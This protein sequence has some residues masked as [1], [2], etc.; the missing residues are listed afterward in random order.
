MNAEIHY[1]DMGSRSIVHLPDT[2]PVMCGSKSEAFA[3]LTARGDVKHDKTIKRGGIMVERYIITV[4]P[5]KVATKATVD[6]D[7]WVTVTVPPRFFWDHVDRDLVVH[8]GKAEFDPET[9]T[10]S[11]PPFVVREA[12]KKI[13]VRLHPADAVDLF[14]DAQHY[15]NADMFEWDLQYLVSSA[16]ATVY[17][18][19]KQLGW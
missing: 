6:S 5:A 1:P 8:S 15:S 10:W 12:K 2:D 4:E 9:R 13:T 14:D 19:K 3:M 11:T 7:G 17:Q 16:R 18:M